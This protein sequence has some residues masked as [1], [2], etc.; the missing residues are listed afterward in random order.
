MS[1]SDNSVKVWDPL[2]RIFHWALVAAFTVAYVTDDEDLLLTHA[3]AGYV[4]IGLLLF[5]LVWGFAGTVHARFSDFIYAPSLVISFMRDTFQ[6]KAK[7]YLGHNPA[8]GWMILLLLLM[9]A[10]ISMTGLLLY[11]ADQHAGPLA[12][13]MAG[14][15]KDTEAL[16]EDLHEFFANL[17]VFLVVVHLAGVVMESVLNKE[18][19]ARAMV[20]GYKRSEDI[21]LSSGKKGVKGVT[22]IS[23]Y[24][25]IGLGM[26]A[27]V[28]MGDVTVAKA[29]SQEPKNLQAIDALL[30]LEKL[31]DKAEAMHTGRLLEAELKSI[32]GTDVYEIEILDEAGK[33]WEMYFNAKTGELMNQGE[34]QKGAGTSH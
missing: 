7:R 15:G 14:T 30:P 31:I 26:F 1:S 8:G 19:L 20:T 34:D 28:T 32:N 23:A 25:L 5:R 11:G 10:L 21:G 4:V 9:L 18:N 2:V 22:Y 17:T 24:F 6:G 16:L 3:W 33:V 27:L 13:L 12:G 29:D